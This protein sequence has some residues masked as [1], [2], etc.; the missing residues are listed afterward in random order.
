MDKKRSFLGWL[1]FGNKSHNRSDVIFGA[2]VIYSTVTSIIAGFLLTSAGSSVHSWESYRELTGN[3]PYYLLFALH[4]WFIT[5]ALPIRDAIKSKYSKYKEYKN[6]V[7]S[8]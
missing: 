5:L 3:G 6:K 2:V 4:G 8:E 7:E 1:L